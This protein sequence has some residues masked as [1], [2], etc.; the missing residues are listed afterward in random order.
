MRAVLFGDRAF[1]SAA[2]N[3]CKH[4]KYWKLTSF[5]KE[6]KTF[7]F[8]P[9]SNY[10]SQSVIDYCIL[11]ALEIQQI[12]ISSSRSRSR[13]RSRSSEN[14]MKDFATKFGR[15]YVGDSPKTDEFSFEGTSWSA[16]YHCPS[17]NSLYYYRPSVRRYDIKYVLWQRCVLCWV[18]F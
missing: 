4:S 1:V 11:V 7:L 14:A 8:K 3:L 13:R 9:T 2:P 15:I 16:Y 18:L 5:K 6:I 17:Q 10:L 12:I